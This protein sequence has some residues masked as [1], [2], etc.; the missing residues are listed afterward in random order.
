LRAQYFERD[1][2]LLLQ[3]AREQ[4][5]RK[6]TGAERADDF[7]AA[8]NWFGLHGRQITRAR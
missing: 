7:V 4:R 6:S 1:I 8:G 2:A 3:I 5:A